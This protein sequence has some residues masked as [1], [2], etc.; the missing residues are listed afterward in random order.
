MPQSG[1]GPIVLAPGASNLAKSWP[2]DAWFALSATLHE[3]FSP[4]LLVGGPL[5][6]W[7]EI[8]PDLPELIEL[9]S[10]ARAFI[11]PDSGPAHLARRL[12]VPTWVVMTEEER[13][14][15]APHGATVVPGN[16]SLV[17]LVAGVRRSLGRG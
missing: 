3:W 4:V 2:L 5:E 14:L 11:G 12:G 13:S 9:L 1:Q 17:D 15:W 8:R 10:A 6:P 7:A 16:T